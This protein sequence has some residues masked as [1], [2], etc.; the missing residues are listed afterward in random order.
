[1]LKIGWSQTGV[2]VLARVPKEWKQ[3]KMLPNSTAAGQAAN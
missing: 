2:V 3:C 1:M